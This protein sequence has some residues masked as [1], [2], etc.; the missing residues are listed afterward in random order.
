MHI[1]IDC[2]AQ[3]LILERA[4]NPL[5]KNYHVA[6]LQSQGCMRILEIPNDINVYKGQT[7]FLT[8]LSFLFLNARQHFVPL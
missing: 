7:F 3:L 6:L 4:N 2:V 1:F 8:S 5:V